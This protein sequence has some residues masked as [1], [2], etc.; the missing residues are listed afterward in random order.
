M[1]SQK[2]TGNLSD[3]T[4]K[5]PVLSGMLEV[6]DQK[7][8]QE[9]VKLVP[10]NKD[11]FAE[12]IRRYEKALLRYVQRLGLISEEDR[13]DVVQNTFIKA[14][15]NIQSFDTKLS[16]SSWLYRIAHNE[17][18]SFFRAR[19]VRPEG[20]MVDNAEEFIE[21]MYDDHEKTDV[22]ENLNQN[23]N[24]NH[25]NQALQKIDEKYRNVLILRY[26]E[27]R[28]YGD[29][30]DILQIPPGSVATLIHRAKK[31]LAKHL[32]HIQ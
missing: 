22:A 16:F 6:Q 1:D 8:D 30:S 10:T 25:V 31:Q 27:E 15:R 21:R 24:A 23:I 20:N 3:Q 26:F 17:T 28:E 12:L 11:A 7:T 29:I 32:E 14:Y 2:D 9:I 13:I 19:K 18:I 4:V 5:A